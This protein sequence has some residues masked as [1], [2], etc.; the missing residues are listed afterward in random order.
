MFRP[1]SKAIPPTSAPGVVG[2]ALD[3]ERLNAMAGAGPEHRNT[4][5]RGR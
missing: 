3:V 5:G 2:T 1:T 4:R